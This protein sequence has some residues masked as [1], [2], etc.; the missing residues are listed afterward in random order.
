MVVKLK[1]LPVC[2]SSCILLFK[3]SGGWRNSP[4]KGMALAM[5]TERLL[6]DS[7]RYYGT[8]LGCGAEADSPQS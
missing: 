2:S 8:R 1:E 7:V 3:V 5:A 4:F 6:P